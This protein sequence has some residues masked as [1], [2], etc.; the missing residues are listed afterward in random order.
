MSEKR[1][2]K[3]AFEF[4]EEHEQEFSLLTIINY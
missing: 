3:H 4:K 1:K 2:L